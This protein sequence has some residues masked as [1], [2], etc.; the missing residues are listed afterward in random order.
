MA[1]DPL[2][3]SAERAIEGVL[4]AA[5]RD[6]EEA[7]AEVDRTHRTLSAAGRAAERTRADEQAIA[8]S[9]RGALIRTIPDL[10]TRPI[11]GPWDRAIKVRQDALTSLR[12]ADSAY[13]AA[14]RHSAAAVDSL[15]AI[16]LP[17][18]ES[19][20]TDEARS[21]IENATLVTP[22][23]HTRI[24]ELVRDVRRYSSDAR[25][26]RVFDTLVGIRSASA[27][28]GLAQREL[29]ELAPHLEV[30]LQTATDQLVNQLADLGRQD[31][32]AT[33]E[34]SPE[35]VTLLNHTMHRGDV[36]EILIDGAS[37]IASHAAATYSPASG[38]IRIGRDHLFFDN[39]VAVGSSLAHELRH[40][41]DKWAYIGRVRQAVDTAPPAVDPDRAIEHIRHLS[42]DHEGMAE[43]ES[44]RHVVRRGVRS[45]ETSETETSESLPALRRYRTVWDAADMA[46]RAGFGA[47][48]ASEIVA[49]IT[50]SYRHSVANSAYQRDITLHALG[51]V[52]S[53][54]FSGDGGEDPLRV[55]LRRFG[56][57]LPEVVDATGP[58]GRLCGLPPGAR[59]ADTSTDPP[60][61]IRLSPQM[62]RDEANGAIWP[63]PSVPHG[64]PND[65][66]AISQTSA[67]STA[68][69]A[70]KAIPPSTPQRLSGIEAGS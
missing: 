47:A 5:E 13:A 28:L 49:R 3:I 31:L 50:S 19:E 11:R 66:L 61:A 10:L 53:E 12:R 65:S 48:P 30:R 7:A 26:N 39:P 29:P 18:L 63:A 37:Q 51:T 15:D 33:V 27:A 6:V 4:R 8:G 17:D 55:N 59:L 42:W 14:L 24:D 56:L 68:P 40:A 38:K 22:A 2:L 43:F 45:S 35:L 67:D 32:L 1:D 16:R 46:R 70:T 21:L 54:H 60:T 44:L 20:L 41:F 57:T 25:Y 52:A 23:T 58:G 34:S 62:S 9:W 64:A 69:G 36:Q